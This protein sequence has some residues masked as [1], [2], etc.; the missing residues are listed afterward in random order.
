MFY[1]GKVVKNKISK[2]FFP[3]FVSKGK[4]ISIGL[5]SRI[6]S[7]G[8]GTYVSPHIS[9]SPLPLGQSIGLKISSVWLDSLVFIIWRVGQYS[10]S[11]LL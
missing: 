2:L 8:S 9:A 1:L 7:A 6:V 3:Y 4:K 5:A 11:I 10:N